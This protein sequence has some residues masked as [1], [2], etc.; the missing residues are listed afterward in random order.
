M[1]QVRGF[2]CNC[3]YP[4]YCDSQLGTLPLTRLAQLQLQQ[5][6][7]EPA[8]EY[9]AAAAAAAAE[10]S[11]SAAHSAVRKCTQ[12][13]E[14]RI[15]DEAS[16]A[17]CDSITVAEE[18]AAAEAAAKAMEGV[19]VHAVYDSIAGHFSSTRFAV[20]PKVRAFLQSLPPYCVVADVGCGNGKYFGVRTDVA[21]LGSDRSAG[22]LAGI[23][24]WPHHRV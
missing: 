19:H 9:P 17:A 18:D 10:D 11:G 24:R 23:S 13:P 14:L 15:A 7:Q 21:V 22:G 1:L 2:P 16:R 6:Q 4:Q 8:H 5:Q 3:S 12:P 20:W